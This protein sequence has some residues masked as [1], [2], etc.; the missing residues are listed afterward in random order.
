MWV[1]QANTRHGLVTAFLMTF[2]CGS[3]YLKKPNGIRPF[4]NFL[5]TIAMTS[6]YLRQQPRD[7]ARARREITERRQKL[8]RIG[9]RLT[10]I[11]PA[12]WTGFPVNDNRGQ[13][14]RFD[15]VG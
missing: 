4:V 7:Q 12:F 2:L 3:L 10:H 15:K 8:A 5:V 1:D 11:D 14:K 9:M 13:G 6:P